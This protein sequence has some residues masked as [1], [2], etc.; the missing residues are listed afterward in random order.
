MPEQPGFK[1]H[2]V[3]AG[4]YSQDAL[5]LKTERSQRRAPFEPARYSGLKPGLPF[6]SRHSLIS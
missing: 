4:G 6:A 3:L 1:V 5:I 2:A